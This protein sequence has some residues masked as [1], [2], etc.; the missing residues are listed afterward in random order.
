MGG[1]TTSSGGASVAEGVATARAYFACL[2]ADGGIQGRP[3]KYITKDDGLS[4]SLAASGAETLV[5]DRV[6]GIVG[7]SYLECPVAGPIYAKA[8]LYEIEGVGGSSS[9]FTSKNIASV[10][11]GAPLAGSAIAQALIKENA[12]RIYLILPNIP[13][14]GTALQASSEATAK[15]MGASIV[16]TEFYTPGIT[17]ATSLVLAAQASGAN[18]VGVVGIKS[19]EL[20]IFAAAT[21]QHL[22]E[23][24]ASGNQLYSPEVPAELGSYWD[25]GKLVVQHQYAPESAHTAGVAL[26]KAVVKRYAPHTPLD[27]DS[28]GMFIAAQM[29]SDTI[30][31]IKGPIT[32]ASVRNALEH[33]KDY[34]TDMLCTQFSW[35]KL[36]FRVSNVD[37]RLVTV[38]GS[39]WKNDGGCAHIDD[40]AA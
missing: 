30:A 24:F 12:K 10:S 2:N 39:S 18:G 20:T 34:R 11:E 37:T 19:D 23:K 33:I 36:P 5:G 40:P 27:E 26:W 9:C 31:K 4:A 15:A 1:E 32:R 35:G 25:N 21:A 7:G 13:G 8:G 14:L 22:T 28:E 3:I 29:F 38:A 6:V 16:G 17:D